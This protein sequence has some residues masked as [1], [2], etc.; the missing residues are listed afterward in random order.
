ME[1]VEF[2]QTEGNFV[3]IVFFGGPD[4]DVPLLL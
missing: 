3:I 1:A 4:K 2:A